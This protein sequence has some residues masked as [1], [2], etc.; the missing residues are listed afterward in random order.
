MSHYYTKK[1]LPK[2]QPKKETIEYLL[3]YSKQLK[4][5]ENKKKNP[6]LVNLN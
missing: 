3:S 4:A 6:I 2:T 5:L 1:T